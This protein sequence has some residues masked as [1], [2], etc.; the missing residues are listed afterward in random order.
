LGIDVEF[1]RAI[2]NLL[3]RAAEAGYGKEEVAAVIK[4][5]RSETSP[6]S[7]GAPRAAD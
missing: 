6:T 1:P 7:E 3:N 5:M 4:V 2:C